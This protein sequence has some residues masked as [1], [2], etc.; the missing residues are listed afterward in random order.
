MNKPATF[1]KRETQEWPELPTLSPEQEARFAAYMAEP[2]VLPK[3]GVDRNGMRLP[4]SESEEERAARWEEF[5]R[6][7]AEID[8]ADDDPPISLEQFKWEMNEERR[9]DGARLLYPEP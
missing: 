5:K 6:R 1:D 4:V 3:P 2:K 8:A 7:M 9:R